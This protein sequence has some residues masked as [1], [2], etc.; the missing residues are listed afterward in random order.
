MRSGDGLSK[1]PF[2]L[3]ALSHE[4]VNLQSENKIDSYEV[5]GPKGDTLR[6]SL[7][8]PFNLLHVGVN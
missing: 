7:K 3:P 4:L 8:M 2:H 5:K 6:I 1:R